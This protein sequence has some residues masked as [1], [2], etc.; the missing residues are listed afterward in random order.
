MRYRPD[1]WHLLTL[2]A[3]FGSLFFV[4]WFAIVVLALLGVLPK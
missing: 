1:W 4:V 3:T 2:A